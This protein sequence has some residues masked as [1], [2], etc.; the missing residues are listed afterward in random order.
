MF[1]NIFKFWRKNS[2]MP[3]NKVCQNLGFGTKIQIFDAF[4]NEIFKIFFGANIQKY[5]KVRFCQN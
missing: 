4:Q 3:K 2:N 1:K 5:G